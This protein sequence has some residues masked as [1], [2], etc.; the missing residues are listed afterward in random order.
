MEVRRVKLKELFLFFIVGVVV[1]YLLGRNTNHYNWDYAFNMFIGSYLG[2]AIIKGWK[3]VI[4]IAIPIW[5]VLWLAVYFI[6][7]IS[8]NPISVI[9]MISGVV[10]GFLLGKFKDKKFLEPSSSKKFD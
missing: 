1:M 2:C 8:V 4:L 3:K 9:I 7:S 10:F 5:L 6:Q